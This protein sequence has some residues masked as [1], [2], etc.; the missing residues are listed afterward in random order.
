[1]KNDVS[2]RYTKWVT[3]QGEIYTGYPRETCTAIN[4]V[5]STLITFI[6]DFSNKGIDSYC[7][8]RYGCCTFDVGAQYFCILI[9]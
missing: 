3:R 1:M 6:G 4:C 7:F 2:E 8:C 5:L 9:L